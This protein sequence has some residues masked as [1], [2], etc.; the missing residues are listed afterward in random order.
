MSSTGAR[1][2]MKK[3]RWGSGG[4]RGGAVVGG[5]DG[6]LVILII[7]FFLFSF[8]L[9]AALK[10]EEKGRKKVKH[11]TKEIRQRNDPSFQATTR[12]HES[13]YRNENRTKHHHY[14]TPKKNS[15]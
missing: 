6:F 1:E 5:G 13:F 12:T 10:K 9:R 15:I 11:R 3:E 14:Y 8:P 2:L 4:G 7:P